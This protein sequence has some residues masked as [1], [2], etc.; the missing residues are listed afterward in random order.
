MNSRAER[1]YTGVPFCYWKKHRHSLQTPH[2][3]KN[4][5]GQFQFCRRVSLCTFQRGSITLE[6]ALV[7]PLFLCAAA[8][9]ICLFSLS[10]AHAK[11][12]R[13]LMEKAQ[14]LAVTAGQEATEDPYILLYDSVSAQLL[15]PDIFPGRKRMVCKAEVRAWVGYTGE[16]F[17][18]RET[19][20][21]VYRTPEGTVYHRRRDCTY[22]QLTIHT[23]SADCLE[24][25]RNLSGGK[26]ASCEYCSRNNTMP[27]SVYITDYGT[28]YHCSRECQ[29]LKRTVMAVPLSETEGLRGCLRCGSS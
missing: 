21:M 18:D 6:A 24:E 29:G 9:L 8:A 10:P 28:S 26:Y 19:E 7:L 25:A 3:G 2:D 27:A 12:E 16:S 14:L 23:I 15:F 1:R 4:Y 11:K 5:F 20:T 13:S 17:S 22:L